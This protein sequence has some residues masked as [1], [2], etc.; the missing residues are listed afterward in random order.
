MPFL[1]RRAVADPPPQLEE[2]PR[3][4]DTRVADEEYGLALA[5]AGSL[6]GVEEQAQ[7]A[8]PADERGETASDSTSSRVRVSC[9]PM[10][11]HALTGSALPLRWTSPIARVSK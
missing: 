1:P 9:S 8:L 7:L 3:L 11:S 6:E 10:I 4:P 2:E 5:G